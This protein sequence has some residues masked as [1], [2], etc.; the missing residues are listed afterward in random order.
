MAI[1]LLAKVQSAGAKKIASKGG[2]VVR[3][4][5]TGDSGKR[6]YNKMDNLLMISVLFQL[7]T[8]GA[9][10][11]GATIDS[12]KQAVA[13]VARGLNRS[14]NSVS[15]KLCEKKPTR[16]GQGK[17][18][19]RGVS[20]EF[21]NLFEAKGVGTLS[22]GKKSLEEVQAYFETNINKAFFQAYA[23]AFN[24]V[25]DVVQAGDI[26][27]AGKKGEV[28]P[29]LPEETKEEL[30]TA[31]RITPEDIEDMMMGLF[32]AENIESFWNNLPEIIN[33]TEIVE[34]TEETSEQVEEVDEAI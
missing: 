21:Y 13:L 25:I 32:T 6:L 29:E 4:K 1:N 12:E 24:R 8:Q 18:D 27:V 23:N 31:E 22:N 11:L 33:E 28:R 34:T 17:M 30:L 3:V 15:F 26:E 5:S 19:F 7:Q 10:V 20:Q 2:A 9:A 14:L 16:I